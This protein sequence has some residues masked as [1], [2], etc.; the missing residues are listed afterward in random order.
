[1]STT[2][3][4]STNTTEPVFKAECVARLILRALEWQSQLV[5]MD[6]ENLD[7]QTPFAIARALVM[8]GLCDS[9]CLPPL[10]CDL[11]F[12]KEESEALMEQINKCSCRLPCAPMNG[13]LN[14]MMYNN[15]FNTNAHTPSKA[16]NL[17]KQIAGGAAGGNY[18]GFPM[19]NMPQT[20]GGSSKKSGSSKK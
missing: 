1:M 20:R 19:M 11:K 15:W 9:A 2:T 3:T 18:Y 10:W 5:M 16:N 13:M 4:S 6:A 17:L 7:P 8:G 14:G 12:T